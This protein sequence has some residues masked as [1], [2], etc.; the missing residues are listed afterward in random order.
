MGRLAVASRFR[1]GNAAE[2]DDIQEAVAHEA[3]RPVDTA[4]VFTGGIEAGYLRFTLSADTD[5]AILVMQGRIDQ[6][7]LL[8]DIDAKF[9]IHVD[10]GR[11]ALF[12]G[13]FAVDE[14]DHGRV[15]P[16]S[17]SVEGIDPFV[18]F[19]TF[20]D[21]GRCD[22]VTRF[23]GMEEGF[24]VLI[25][26]HG[27]ERADLFRHQGAVDLRRIGSARRMVLDG[28]GIDEGHAGAVGHDQAV[29]RRAVVIGRWEALV[30][31]AAGTACGDDD[32]L[33]PD[34]VVFPGIEVIE[35]GTGRLPF[36]IE[37]EFH[38]R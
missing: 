25:D 36:A 12:H 1:P 15:E 18:P 8:A 17:R 23:Q 4:D 38:S 30:V 32:A 10:H 37:E 16:D 3:V 24:A 7:G 6:D 19:L 26:Q 31:E 33:G 14:V 34:D 22:D 11:Q 5:A 35:D 29:G 28:V 9:F 21:D 13:P 2:D 27:P 20:A